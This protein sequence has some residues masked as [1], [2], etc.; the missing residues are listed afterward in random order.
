[1]RIDKKWRIL[2]LSSILLLVIASVLV[3][4]A[5]SRIRSET[6]TQTKGP[7]VYNPES[8]KSWQIPYITSKVKDLKIMG[9]SVSGEGTLGATLQIGVMNNSD[10][11][12][13]ALEF[14]AGDEK[15]VSNLGIDGQQ[16]DP[17]SPRVVIA[18]HTLETFNWYLGSIYQDRPITLAAAKFANG[19][20]EGNEETLRVMRKDLERARA[21]KAKEGAKQ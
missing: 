19:V 14:S 4:G 7:H 20:E 15:D 16:I 17:D 6:K 8:T 2:M 10:Q 11:G 1:M 9:I 21:R 13:I 3:I 18:P 12:V 5:F